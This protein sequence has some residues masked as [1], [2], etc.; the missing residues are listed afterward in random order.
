MEQQCKL[1]EI[2]DLKSE[3]EKLQSIPPYTAKVKYIP[4]PKVNTY[5]N[6]KYQNPNKKI[7]H[8]NIKTV[9]DTINTL[10]NEGREDFIKYYTNVADS[11]KAPMPRKLS[12][13]HSASSTTLDNKKCH[14][15][16]FSSDNIIVEIDTKSKPICI[17]KPQ[18]AI[19]KTRGFY[20]LP[21]EVYKESMEFRKSH[22]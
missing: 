11:K 10:L 14:L 8:F 18:T 17:N 5:I 19:T 2:H 9:K 20:N 3:K 4:N 6:K 15:K 12:N 13:K 1:K 16:A 7:T 21:I 22:K